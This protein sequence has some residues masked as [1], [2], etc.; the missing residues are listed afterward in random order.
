ML[1]GIF[2]RGRNWLSIA[3]GVVAQRPEWSVVLADLRQHGASRGFDPPH[4]LEACARDVD[5][6][7]P[8]DAILGH[9]F[10]GK[11]A[12]V[13]GAP[14]VWVVDSDPSAKETAGESM[15]MLR[16]LEKHPRFATRQDA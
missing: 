5:A 6:L 3:K 15:E 11:V 13:A 10:G 14:I 8:R 7:G 12:L 4:D 1:H 2:G 9:S 16:W